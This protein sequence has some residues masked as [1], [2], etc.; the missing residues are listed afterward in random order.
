MIFLGGFGVISFIIGFVDSSGVVLL[1]LLFLLMLGRKC[2]GLFRVI[3]V[4][5]VV[6]LFWVSLILVMLI[7]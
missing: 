4:C 5:I 2:F 3:M 7:W 6:W 1:V